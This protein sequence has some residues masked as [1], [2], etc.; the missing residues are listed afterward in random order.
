MNISFYKLECITNL[1]VGSGDENFNIVDS[2][3]EKDPVTGLPIIGA[4]GVKGALREVVTAQDETLANEIFG[5]RGDRET[6]GGGTHKFFDACLIARPMRVSGSAEFASIPVVTVASVN[7]F[8][9]MLSVFGQNPY[10]FETIEAPDFDGKAFLTNVPEI[11]VEDE[12]T[13]L[14]TG[15]VLD[16]LMKLKDMIGENFA[17]AAT[18]D[19]YDLPIMARNLLQNGIS[20]NLW[21]EEFV[22]HGSVLFF[23]VMAPDDVQMMEMPPIVQFGGNSSIGYGFSKLTKL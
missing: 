10:G 4:S 7:H 5:T 19:G 3:V 11:R 22:P 14:L 18:F 21:F 6:V 23:A 20:K 15:T 13:G 17:L 16:K 1:H 2:E 9:S 8:L 12:E